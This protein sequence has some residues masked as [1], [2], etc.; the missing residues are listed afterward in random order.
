MHN[1][2]ATTA[3][4]V[5]VVFDEGTTAVGGVG[6]VAALALGQVVRPGSTYA[7]PTSHHGLLRTI[8][9]AWGLPRLGASQRYLKHRNRRRARAAL[10]PSPRPDRL[11]RLDQHRVHGFAGLAAVDLVELVPPPRREV[12]DRASVDK[13]RKL[14]TAEES[15]GQLLALTAVPCIG[16]RGR[17]NKPH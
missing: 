7:L 2:G 11:A 3:S 14:W 12:M 13:R 16:C 8:E 10:R 9:D 17:G 1:S 6:S 4:V 5:F 15:C